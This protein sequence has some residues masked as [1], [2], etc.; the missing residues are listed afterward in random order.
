MAERGPPAFTDGLDEHARL[1][2]RPRLLGLIG[3]GDVAHA[4][5]KFGSSFLHLARQPRRG[6]E[7]HRHLL[8]RRAANH[9]QLHGAP[10]LYCRTIVANRSS[11]DGCDASTGSSSI[12]VTMSPTRSP[13][14]DGVAHHPGDADTAAAGEA[15]LF[16]ERLRQNLNGH[17]NPAFRVS[18]P[19]SS[20]PA[21]PTS[22]TV[23]IRWRPRSNATTRPRA[24]SCPSSCST[25][26]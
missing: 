10:I 19:G 11:S 23:S 21:R 4:N 2:F 22:R 14:A 3:H 16:G 20:S 18:R 5:S 7:L 15:E 1:P 8:L 13:A 12:F 9:G 25:T 24:R 6:V 17:R 26:R